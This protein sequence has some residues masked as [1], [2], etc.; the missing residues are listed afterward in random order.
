M[1]TRANGGA[2]D[3]QVD[4]EA[5]GQG[6]CNETDERLTDRLTGKGRVAEVKFIVNNSRI[7]RRGRR[8]REIVYREEDC[9][10]ESVS[11]ASARIRACECG[12]P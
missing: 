2:Q 9:E 5:I 1:D 4:G 7:K 8:A 10:A 3:W 11:R 6:R 12:G